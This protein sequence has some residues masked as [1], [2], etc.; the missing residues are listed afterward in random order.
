VAADTLRATGTVLSEHAPDLVALVSEV[1]E[2]PRL[3]EAELPRIKAD[4]LR[5]RGMMA[6]QPGSIADERLNAVLYP[7][8]AYGRF[9]PTEE[10]IRGYTMEQVRAYAE[11]HVHAG[12]AH[13]YIAGRFDHAAVE[14]AVRAA[15][16]DWRGGAP[17][18]AR[19]VKP[20]SRRV[21]HFID[22]PGAV[23]STVRI[24]IPVVLPSHP[25]RVPLEV[26]N[27]LLG[28]GFS[29]RIT[30]NIREQKGYTYSPHSSLSTNEG[31]VHWVQQADVTT[32][33]TGAAMKEILG[34]IDRLRKTPPSAEELDAVKRRLTGQFLIVQSMRQ[35]R[36]ERQRYLDLHGLPPDH[37]YVGQVMA[38]TPEKITQMARTYLDPKRLT[39]V[40]VGDRKQVTPQLKGIAPLAR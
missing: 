30:S 28:G 23:Q 37:D 40:V 38:V 26:M 36:L 25:D 21:I 17:K 24:A 34:E 35:G 19:A 13:L 12:R 15:F 2:R 7:G 1:V 32:K 18:P 14:A 16:S 31:A 4:L 8:H 33:V 39:M 29:S 5:I 10:M 22:R 27:A 9:F 11:T 20:A 6:A 3:P